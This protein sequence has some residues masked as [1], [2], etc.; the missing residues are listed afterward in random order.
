M[1]HFVSAALLA[2][3]ASTAE[4]QVERLRPSLER[5]LEQRGFVVAHWSRLDTIHLF[6]TEPRRSP[7][8]MATSKFFA[9]EGDARAVEGWR[10]AGF[11]PVQLSA[12]DLF[13]AL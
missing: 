13:P 10:L 6:C 9:Q 2:S 8:D 7:A 12:T 5:I 11:H 4:A 3:I 1:R